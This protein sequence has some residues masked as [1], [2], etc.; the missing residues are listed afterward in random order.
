MYMCE[1]VEG[2]HARVSAGACQGQKMPLDPL[3][4][5]LQVHQAALSPPVEILVTSNMCM[6]TY[7]F[8]YKY[9]SPCAC[10]FIM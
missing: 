8:K 3:E 5:E 10:I 6:D 2:I 7:V 1:S 4:L 9:V